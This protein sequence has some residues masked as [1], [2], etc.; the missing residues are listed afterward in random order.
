M[1]ACCHFATQFEDN[2]LAA[3]NTDYNLLCN[4][5]STIFADSMS[6]H[7]A[8]DQ[9]MSPQQKMPTN[10]NSVK[11]AFSVG[12]NSCLGSE[13]TVE[14]VL[15][16]GHVSLGVQTGLFSISLLAMYSTQTDSISSNMAVHTD[17]SSTQTEPVSAIISQEAQMDKPVSS[18]PAHTKCSL[19][20]SPP[21]GTM[22]LPQCSV[23]VYIRYKNWNKNKQ[24]LVAQ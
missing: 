16:E 20:L 9:L 17:T 18:G 3:L 2:V 19:Q 12:C 21:A 24:E 15:S 8:D 22:T 14:S 13:T 1:E 5:L 10:V 7:R 4:V 11:S 23:I 6:H